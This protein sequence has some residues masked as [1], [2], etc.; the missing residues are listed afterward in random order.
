MEQERDLRTQLL[1]VSDNWEL[2]NQL[3]PRQLSAL[4]AIAIHGNGPR[5][6]EE[7]NISPQ[8]LKNHLT[9]V[10]RAVFG[11]QYFARIGNQTSAGPL[12]ALAVRWALAQERRE[13]ANP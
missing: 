3:S 4:L 8:T 12:V 6:A 10:R 7:L 11:E 9:A 1:R 13:K 5:A 2:L